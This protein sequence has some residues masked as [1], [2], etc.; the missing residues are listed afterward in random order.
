MIG[1]NKIRSQAANKQIVSAENQEPAALTLAGNP[2]AASRERAMGEETK[3]DPGHS[4]TRTVLRTLG[5]ILA[6]LGVLLIVI[7][8]ASFFTTFSSAAG[9]GPAGPPR[10][11]WCFFLGI[12]LLFAGLT[13]CMFG[14]LGAMARYVSGEGAP[15]QKDTFNY[16]AGGTQEGVRTVATAVGAG[17]A[18]G[19]AEA[20]GTGR[21]PRWPR[22]TTAMRGFASTAGAR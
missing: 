5:P 17:L 12:P 19:M 4:T 10:L 21:C 13:M 9:G 7:G 20:R 1:A 3:I 16:L 18:A 14:F 22:P 2:A 6:G 15:V 8:A 11:F